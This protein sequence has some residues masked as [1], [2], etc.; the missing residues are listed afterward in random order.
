M[1]LKQ[2]YLSTNNIIN[3]L[4]DPEAVKFNQTMLNLQLEND[5]LI[6]RNKNLIEERT[7][8]KDEI[9]LSK[10]L[11]QENEL[12]NEEFCIGYEMEIS[13][14]KDQS[15]R[16]EYNLQFLEQ[17]LVD[18]ERFL[19]TLGRDDPFLNDQL[20]LIKINP[21]LNK[22]RITSVVEENSILK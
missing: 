13:R 1:T 22:K 11:N 18:I 2:L 3:S 19:R 12:K 10:Q 5:H 16:K 14:L 21:N 8:L 7:E 15:E 6:T 20:R 9:L 4:L 17:R